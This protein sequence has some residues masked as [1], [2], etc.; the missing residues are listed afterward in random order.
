MV[1]D[2]TSRKGATVVLSI[3]SGMHAFSGAFACSCSYQPGLAPLFILH[4]RLQFFLILVTWSVLFNHRT[5]VLRDTL[6]AKTL[7]SPSIACVLEPLPLHFGQIIMEISIS[8]E[9]TF[10]V[11]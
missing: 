7:L 5:D 1:K 6:F 3:L 10:L 4:E 2:I 11:S 8:R 9:G